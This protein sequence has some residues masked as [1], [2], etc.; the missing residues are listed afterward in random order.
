M[1]VPG[2]SGFCFLPGVGLGLHCPV[3]GVS[4]TPS[5][6]LPHLRLFRVLLPLCSS[7]LVGSC[8]ASTRALIS[9]LLGGAALCAPQ[10]AL[11]PRVHPAPHPTGSAETQAPS[12]PCAPQAWCASLREQAQGPGPQQGKR[13][14]V[15]VVCDCFFSVSDI[16]L[17]CTCR[18]M[19]EIG[20]RSR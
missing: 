5:W 15:I 19:L 14:S 3:Q 11:R 18:F 1:C 13:C 8:M 12:H 2:S 7:F 9:P 17:A 20:L 10:A 16:L 6:A 4:E